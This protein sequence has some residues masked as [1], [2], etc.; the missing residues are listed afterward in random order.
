MLITEKIKNTK[1][2]NSEQIAI[3]F[4][5]SKDVDIK[6]YTTTM[7]ATSTY[8]SPSILV[9]IAKKLGFKGYND[10][11]AAYLKELSYLRSNFTN[12]DANIPFTKDDN[13]MNIVNKVA[14]IKKES[15]NDTINLIEHDSLQK[16]LRILQKAKTI[17]LFTIS[18]LTYQAEQFVFRMRHIGASCETYS[19]SN[20]F[21]QEAKMTKPTDCAIVISYSG[22]SADTLT[23][24]KYFKENKVP[25]I[26]ITSIGGNSLSNLADVS[27]NI[28]TR[29][30][31][32]SKIANYTS[33]ES[34]TLILDI[35]YSLYFAS[36]Y[37][38]HFDYKLEI[39]RGT[40]L[41]N[42]SNQIIE[43]K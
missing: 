25:I 6:D 18:D 23:N 3:D 34:I 31:S 21:Y 39:S 20:T 24:L 36:D 42:I 27:L 5:I 2:S 29:E 28:T 32:Y 37:Q 30:K 15:I 10:F 17:K 16:A 12:I 11:K 22:E 38:K 43:E 7:I 40:E 33:L 41:R 1:F 4:I 26:A 8:T 14:T 35:L 19:F 13:M 9:R